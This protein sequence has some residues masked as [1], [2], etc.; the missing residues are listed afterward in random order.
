[1]GSFMGVCVCVVEIQD[2]LTL[3]VFAKGDYLHKIS[4]RCVSMA[5]FIVRYIKNFVIVPGVSACQL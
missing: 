3:Q 1:M 5:V 4:I 2:L